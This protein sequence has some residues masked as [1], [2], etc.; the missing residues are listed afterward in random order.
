MVVLPNYKYLHVKI[1][2]SIATCPF[3]AELKKMAE[4]FL[5]FQIQKIL[6]L[7]QNSDN[8]KM[9][10]GVATFLYKLGWKQV[11]RHKFAGE[12]KSKNSGI[13]EISLIIKS[14]SMIFT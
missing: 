13:A 3:E 9:H 6:E 1:I 8:T 5:E 4:R 10:V 14:S 11:V 2:V 12:I 7:N